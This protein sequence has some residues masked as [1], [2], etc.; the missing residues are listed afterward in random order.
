MELIPNQ[1]VLNKSLCYLREPN[2]INNNEDPIRTDTSNNTELSLGSGHMRFLLKIRSSQLENIRNPVN[3]INKSIILVH[4]P[5]PFASVLVLQSVLNKS[6]GVTF[7]AILSDF[8]DIMELRGVVMNHEKKL[9]KQL[10]KLLKDES[11]SS[12]EIADALNLKED[13]LHAELDYLVDIKLCYKQFTNAVT[14]GNQLVGTNPVYGLTSFG[15]DYFSNKRNEWIKFWIPVI[16][17]IIAILIS[18]I[19]LYFTFF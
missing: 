14:I 10:I 3:P 12:Q 1:S 11:K 6:F 15:K 7:R 18:A 19:S 2:R 13:Q 17:S 4:T 8:L 5:Y 16:I 9:M